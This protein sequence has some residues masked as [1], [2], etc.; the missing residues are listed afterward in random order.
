M[1]WR[2]VVSIAATRAASRRSWLQ[3]ATQKKYALD[4]IGMR[5]RALALTFA[6]AVLLG[7]PA[8]HAHSII[9][10][11]TDIGGFGVAEPVAGVIGG[12]GR[13]RLGL[14][15]DPV[16]DALYVEGGVAAASW[17]GHDST[18]LYADMAIAYRRY[19]DPRAEHRFFWALG[20]RGAGVTLHRS[21]A[22][23]PVVV[24]FGPAGVLGYRFWRHA[25]I[26]VAVQPALALEN[27]SVGVGAPV[28]LG[29]DLVAF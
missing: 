23:D 27:E 9:V 17:R 18:A 2:A 16:V 4:R 12:G 28:M 19:I 21:G 14:G 5:S 29:L 1:E 3:I 7:A 20:L 25:E 8:A 10:L 24:Y 6:A 13:L 11:V 26:Y 22:P 15:S